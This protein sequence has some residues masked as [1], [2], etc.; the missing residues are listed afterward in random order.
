M[1]PSCPAPQ[2]HQTLRAAIPTNRPE[3]GPVGYSDFIGG[4]GESVHFPGSGGPDVPTGAS[5]RGSGRELQCARQREGAN[6]QN[7]R[8]RTQSDRVTSLQ[9]QSEKSYSHEIP[10]QESTRGRTAACESLGGGTAAPWTRMAHH[11][12][13]QYSSGLRFNE[14]CLCVLNVF[15]I[16][17]LL[18]HFFLLEREYLLYLCST[19][20][21]HKHVTCLVI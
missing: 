18:S 5:G 10:I 4:G 11:G 6:I 7:S 3:Y 12:T 20:I 15:A 1:T 19:T 9:F 21:V 13:I 8:A 17:S 16:T 2:G 14:I